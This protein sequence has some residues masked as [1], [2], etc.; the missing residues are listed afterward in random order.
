MNLAILLSQTNLNLSKEE[1]LTLLSN[2]KH[3]LENNILLV[4][5][6]NI[7]NATK[8]LRNAAFTK[9]VFALN[10]IPKT[11]T[12]KLVTLKITKSPSIDEGL[13]Y[14]QHLKV[15][16]KNPTHEI[17]LI[18]LTKTRVGLKVF[19]NK[20]RFEDRKPHKRPKNHPTSINP[21]LARAM[22][23]L[24]D[25]KKITD[26]F[27]GSGGI[28]IEGTITNHIMTGIEISSKLASYCQENL[29]FYNLNAKILVKDATMTKT[30]NNIV[31]DIPYGKNSFKSDST[32]N[33]IKWLFEQKSKRIILCSNK[34]IKARKGF[35]KLKSFEIYVHKSMTRHIAIYQRSDILE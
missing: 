16:L 8:Q 20:E 31:T 12:C 11:K 2:P 19:E 17:Y 9:K 13:K 21:R 7:N 34:K 1:A 6:A 23:N 27:C 18:G 33:L 32:N 26:P 24:A 15:N 3:R 14:I 29:K 35:K 4:K 28:L 10:Q 30:S 25:S 22:I 5:V